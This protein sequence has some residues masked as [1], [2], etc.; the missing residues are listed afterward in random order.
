MK[1]V[2]MMTQIVQ[3]RQ[4]KRMIKIGSRSRL[5]RSG[6]KGAR[7]A[8]MMCKDGRFKKAAIENTG[9]HKNIFQKI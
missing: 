6:K 4:L 8:R 2:L 1:K 3:L 7:K 9:S 5:K